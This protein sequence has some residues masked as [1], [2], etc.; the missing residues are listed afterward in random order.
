MSESLLP[1]QASKLERA[2]DNAASRITQVPVSLSQL[3]DPWHCPVHFLPWLADGLSVDSWDNLWPEHIQRQVIADSVPNHRIKGTAGAVKQ[4][5]RSLNASVELQEWWQTGGAPHSAELL[6]LAHDNLD[7]QGDTL[8]TP[9]LQ[10]QLWQTVAATKPCRSQIQFRVG[11]A[12][13]AECSLSNMAASHSMS[14]LNMQA[15]P[16]F[17]FRTELFAI[18]GTD[19]PSISDS[20]NQLNDEGAEFDEHSIVLAARSMGSCIGTGNF[21][22]QSYMRFEGES[23]VASKANTLSIQSVKMTLI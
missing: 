20:T 7:P 10:A 18:A 8:L 14:Q 9:K 5:L 11:V 4:S 15:S 23:E 3:W 6:A 1:N 2:L 13:S 22:Q 12:Q 16:A 19:K 17:T 21:E